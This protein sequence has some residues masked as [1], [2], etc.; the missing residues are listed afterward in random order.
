MKPYENNILLAISKACQTTVVFNVLAGSFSGLVSVSIVHV[1]AANLDDTHSSPYV[2]V[3]SWPFGTS[4]PFM[5]H[6]T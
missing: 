6:K 5:S 2:M 4:L 1:A 3:I